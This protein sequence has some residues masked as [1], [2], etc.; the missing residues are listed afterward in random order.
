MWRVLA[1]Q[2]R[3]VESRAAKEKEELEARLLADS[4]KRLADLRTK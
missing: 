2:V 3:R 1:W 4:E